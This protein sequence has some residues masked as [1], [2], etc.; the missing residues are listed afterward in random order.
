M[1]KKKTGQAKVVDMRLE[2]FVDWTNL[3]VSKSAEMYGLISSFAARMCKQA[4]SAQG[5]TAPGSEV[6][7]GNRPKL[8]GQDEEA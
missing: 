5:E 7:S 6:P 4:A 8:S 1:K 3:R 2:G